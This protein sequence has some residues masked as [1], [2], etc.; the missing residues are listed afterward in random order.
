M[1]RIETRQAKKTESGCCLQHRKAS[2]IGDERD[3]H[4]CDD[5]DKHRETDEF[6]AA[7]PPPRSE[8]RYG[9]KIAAA[10]K[11]GTRGSPTPAPAAER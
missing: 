7:M 6:G 10:A 5:C 8:D 2:I 1:Q 9:G 3:R 11:A 4:A